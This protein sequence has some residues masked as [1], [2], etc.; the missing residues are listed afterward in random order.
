MFGRFCLVLVLVIS[1]ILAGC[2]QKP[3]AEFTI[4]FSQ[5]TGGDE[6]RRA[7][8]NGMQRELAFHS[9]VE[10]LYR[11]AKYDNQ[12]QIEQIRELA[13]S[14]IDLLIVSPNE[15]QP[16]TPVV[17][18]VYR[19][20]IPV[21]VV[22]RRISSPLYSAFV[23]GNNGEVG[24]LAGQYIQ[25]LLKGK[26]KV[27][28]I[29]GSPK[30][31]PAMDRHQAF[32]DQVASSPDIKV[33]TINGEWEKQYAR[34][35]LLQI[36]DQH[37]DVDLIF[38]HNDRMTV[39]AYEVCK[40]KGLLGK[41]KFVGIDGLAGKTGG[42]QMVSDSIFKATILYSPGGEEAIRT[43]MKILKKDSYDKETILQTA[44]ID[45][46]N[47][48]MMKQQTDKI[49]LQQEDIETQQRK[50]DDQ[51]K[52][53][54]NQ[55]MFLYG[56]SGLLLVTIVA[57]SLALYSLTEN[58]KI[59]R[60]LKAKNAEILEQRNK[61]QEMAEKAQEATES[62][63]RFFT[64]ISHEFRTPLT[65]I[66]APIEEIVA[67]KKNQAS[68]VKKDLLLIH[69]NALRLLRLVNQLMDF[70]K[71][72][73]GKIM[74]KATQTDLIALVQE[75]MLPFEIVAKKRSIDF[76]LITK[77]S[78][79]P[80]WI[81]VD[82]MDTVL[83]NLL[84]NAFKF[85]LDKGRIYVYIEQ[86]ASGE[87]AILKV[88]DTGVGMSEEEAASAFEMFYQGSNASAKGTGLGLPLSQEL[89]ELHQGK[90]TVKSEKYKGTVFTIELPLGK[91]HFTGEA[92]SAEKPESVL[93]EHFAL[94]HTEATTLETAQ[95]IP[96]FLEQTIL[97]IEDN[98]D[99][100]VF[101]KEK[102]Q[103]TFQITTAT[104]GNAGMKE[105]F[106]QIPDLIICDIMLPDTDGLKI[107]STLKTDIRTSHIP[108]IL[109]TAKTTVEQQIEGI[110]TG[111]DL[112]LTKPFN[113]QF[114]QENIRSLLSNRAILKNHYTGEI[115]PTSKAGSRLSK[116]DKK[117]VTDFKAIIDSRIADPSLTVDCLCKEL[118]LSRVQLYRKVKALLGVTINDYIQSIRLNKACHSLQQP[119]VSVADIAYEV[120][121]SSPAYFSTAFKARY[122]L[123]P[124]EYRNQK[125][126]P[127]E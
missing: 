83:F 105:A 6:W 59:N 42:L 77:L 39:S 43:A 7:M 93:S 121:F 29:T 99:L 5:C 66:L 8:L 15:D 73:S 50:I 96:A 40:E 64:N 35:A 32:M 27:I 94:Q 69:K 124:L 88:E 16:I 12:K 1:H 22:D 90:I 87:K 97:I 63:F 21:V 10:L 82:M 67:A 104:D 2:D 53:Y 54:Q 20:G 116:V 119:G 65:L 127:Q 46:S 72:E 81:D 60:E 102:L 17:E 9:N 13:N 101:L 125:Y 71:I 44:V 18:E 95:N 62:K 37:R 38:G 48:H 112:Y 56:M 25:M 14:D 76:Q 106:E 108:I 86:D 47:V 118:G 79:L 23:G 33:V 61:V 89:V 78:S 98:E 26:G 28:E 85:T 4:G 100:Q 68:M 107:T 84:S 41:V 45:S 24:K 80:A 57:G 3:A 111:A 34:P 58:K 115:I 51:L 36:I 122:G 31:S 109:L 55:Q 113:L 120:G 30:S 49:L 123:S 110:Q 91:T 126:S 52:I 114:L 74:V 92:L 75:T 11:D 117:F 19:M 103:S 70:R